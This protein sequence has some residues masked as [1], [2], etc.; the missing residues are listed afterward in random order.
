MEPEDVVAAST[1]PSIAGRYT[2]LMFD[3]D[4]RKYETWEVKFLAYMRLRKLRDVILPPPDT[5]VSD[6]K[7]AGAFAE[8]I[9]F[10]D[11]KSLSL[12]MRDA[13]DDGKRALEMLRQ[14]YAGTSK[15]RIITLYTELTSLS[16]HADESVTDY[17]IRAEKQLQH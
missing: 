12:A 10:L 2:R 6:D 4:E 14:H 3:G 11:D 9:Q 1:R 8:L 5:A 16:K 13:A 17:I 15:P 7:N